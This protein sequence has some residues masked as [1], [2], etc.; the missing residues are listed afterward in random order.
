MTPTPSTSAPAAK[1]WRPHDLPAAQ[2]VLEQLD[3]LRKVARNELGSLASACTLRAYEPG[4]PLM[5]EHAVPHTLFIILHGSVS[6]TIGDHDE[7]P[8]LITFL[9]RGDICG[10]GGLFGTRYR[11]LSAWAESRVYALQIHYAELE[12]MLGSLPT[13]HKQLQRLFRERLLQ[14][15]LAKVPLLEALNAIERLALAAELEERIFERDDTIIEL[16]TA[17]QSLYLVASG[18]AVMMHSSRP[19]HVLGPGEL[20]GE[21]AMLTHAAQTTAI[22]ALTQV[23]VLL[24]PLDT[25]RQLLREHPEIAVRLEALINQRYVT[26]TDQRYL[27]TVTSALESGLVRGRKAL[28]RIPALCPPDCHLCERA[29][30]ARWGVP[31]IRVHGAT[32]GDADVLRG[33][34]HCIWSPECVEACPEDAI[35]LDDDGFLWVNDRCTGCSVCVSACPYEAIEMIPLYPPSNGPLDWLRHKIRPPAPLRMHANKCDGCHGEEDQACMVA[36]PTGSLRWLSFTDV[37][38]YGYVAEDTGASA[39]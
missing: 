26:V 9:G 5:V 16:G 7:H 24:I 18:Q 8:A 35:K 23:R 6:L 17:S 25:F 32:F 29:C 37:T 4:T 10:E 14:T 11:R 27:A 2:A 36:C 31:R 15:T 34:K 1:G 19:L 28:A 39:L 12:Q 38:P 3:G 30:G 33:C 20:F 21:I 22:R 13:F